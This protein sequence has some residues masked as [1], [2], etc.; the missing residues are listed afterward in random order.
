MEVSFIT[1]KLEI[2]PENLMLISKGSL[3]IQKENSSERELRLFLNA[4]LD[5]GKVRIK[6]GGRSFKLKTTKIDRP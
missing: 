2:Q 3:R 6:Q 1:L 5:W 4:E